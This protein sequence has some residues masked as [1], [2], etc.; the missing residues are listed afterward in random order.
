[1]L[2]CHGLLIIWLMMCHSALA[3]LAH[4][5]FIRCDMLAKHLRIWIF[6]FI[7]QIMETQSWI[8][9]NVKRLLYY[10]RGENWQLYELHILQ[11]KPASWAQIAHTACTISNHY[12][13]VTWR[14]INIFKNF[15]HLQDKMHHHGAREVHNRQ[16]PQGSSSHSEPFP[17]CINW[18]I[19]SPCAA[20]SIIHNALK[21][22]GLFIQ[23]LTA[24]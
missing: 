1:M 11:I 23:G 4:I 12:Y 14:Q 16:C 10:V 13:N 5:H 19:M 20:L 2:G 18:G 17:T 6:L 7:C 22:S 9:S 8:T 21:L 3:N 15:L 24:Q